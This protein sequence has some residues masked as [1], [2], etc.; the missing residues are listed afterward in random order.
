[1]KIPYNSKAQVICG[2]IQL[3]YELPGCG[4]GGCCHIVT[5]D[6]NIEDHNL[7]FVIDWCHDPENS[8]RVE[9]EL[10]C[11]ICELMLQLTFAQRAVLFDMMRSGLCITEDD[12]V[13][14][15]NNIEA[16]QSYDDFIKFWKHEDCLD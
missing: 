7:K 14:H 15:V 3:L 12:W 8:D 9:T 4:A 2:L 5:D 1:M 10:C 13:L 6:D 16:V 11:L